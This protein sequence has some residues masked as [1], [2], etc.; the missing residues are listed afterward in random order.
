M[1]GEAEDLTPRKL[2][3]QQARMEQL[4]YW[5]PKSIPERLAAMTALSRRMNAMRGIF[6]DEQN[7][8]L[9]PSRVRRGPIDKQRQVGGWRYLADADVL[10]PIPDHE[11]N[12]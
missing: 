6:I 3:H 11:I 5:S 7:P 1:A 12:G 2:T 10:A 9:T 4:L 8:D